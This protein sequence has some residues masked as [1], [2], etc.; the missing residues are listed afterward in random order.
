MTP[1]AAMSRARVLVS[2]IMDAAKEPDSTAIVGHKQ[3]RVY[4]SAQELLDCLQVIADAGVGRSAILEK[5]RQIEIRLNAVKNIMDDWRDEEVTEEN[6]DGAARRPLCEL[7][8]K[9][10]DFLG[11]DEKSCTC[12]EPCT[13]KGE[14]DGQP[15]PTPRASTETP[16]EERPDAQTSKPDV[17]DAGSETACA[18]CSLRPTCAHFHEGTRPAGQPCSAFWVA[19]QDRKK[20]VAQGEQTLP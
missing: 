2:D 12:N 1:E 18:L 10:C 14:T 7:P 5:I 11:E 13:F 17:D 8:T 9:I 19:P 20:V 16:G 3:V 4:A 6:A 15:E